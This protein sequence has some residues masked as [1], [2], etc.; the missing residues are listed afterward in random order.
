MTIYGYNVVCS[1]ED[2][3]YYVEVCN[4]KT[5]KNVWTSHVYPNERDAVNALIAKYG[6]PKNRLIRIGD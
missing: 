5:G 1:P 2:E 3:G 4:G 6:G